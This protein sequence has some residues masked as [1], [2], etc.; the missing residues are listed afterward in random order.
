MIKLQLKSPEESRDLSYGDETITIGR[1]A[2]CTIQLRD[3]KASRE[4]AKIEKVGDEYRLVDLDSNNG[5][6]INSEGVTIRP[7]RKGDRISIG[8]CVITVVDVDT[9]VPAAPEEPA[10]PAPVPYEKKLEVK[11]KIEGVRGGA[12]KSA[13]RTGSDPTRLLLI[14]GGVAAVLVVA[15]VLI[16]VVANQPMQPR[17]DQVNKAK[18]EK[19]QLDRD[20]RLDAEAKLSEAKL[21]AESG[22]VDLVELRRHAQKYDGLL[23]KKDNFSTLVARLEAK[24][25]PRRD[26]ASF[27]SEFASV[28]ARVESA[29]RQRQYGEALR[30]IAGVAAGA[31]ESQ[32]SQV[33]E[34]LW[35]AKKAVYADFQHVIMEGYALENRDEYAKAKEVYS[36]AAP[37]FRDTEYHALL[38]GRPDDIDLIVR[39]K[40]AERK[41]KTEIVRNEPKKDEP[42]KDDPGSKKDEPV[43][44]IDTS[45]LLKKL[46]NAINAGAFKDVKVKLSDLT[47][48]PTSADDSGIKFKEGGEVAWTDIAPK[49]M[50]QLF[51]QLKYE[52]DELLLL[53]EWSHEKGLEAEA[54]K[55]L[56]RYI[57]GKKENKT[58]ADGAIARWRGVPV[59]DGGYTY[60]A[61]TASWEDRG[62]LDNRLAIEDAAKLGRELASLTDIKRVDP[63]VGKLLAHFNNANLKQETRDAVKTAALEALQTYK[64][65]RLESIGQR[66]KSAVGFE[67]LRQLKMELNKRRGEAI[68]VIYDPKIYLPEDHPDWRKGDKANGQTE[69]DRLVEQVRQLWEEGGRFAASLDP[70]IKR[71]IEGVQEINA[72]HLRQFGEEPSEDDLKDFDEIMNNL[73]SR[74]DLKNFALTSK[75]R[76]IWEW[77]R[78]VDRY[79]ETLNDP[80]VGKEEKDHFK[81]VNDYREMMGRR[82]LFLDARLCRA[83]KKHSA[84]QDREGRIWHEG[85]DG[86]PQSRAQAE[87]FPAGV[88]ENVAIGYGSPAEVWTR[89]WYRASDHHRNGLSD[90]WNC[91]GYGYVGRVGSQNFSS[92]SPPKGK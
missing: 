35:Q 8:E 75:E 55:T 3:R 84:A 27:D 12:G 78:W 5:T 47:G 48:E 63:I 60:N 29:L 31:E 50:F 41:P 19:E 59:P 49:S 2:E 62:E 22:E 25:P 83:T 54:N 16:V 36:G 4:H 74:I 11:K 68:K 56:S 72:K 67:K 28:R 46:L 87:G 24:L 64:K 92:I 52:G 57:A 85:P 81:V 21:A 33:N 70:Q 53:A 40:Q 80:S 89:G 71:D 32:Q 1:K 15:V 69:V 77:N 88:G 13:L 17:P 65:K 18:L 86:S 43:A 66:A 38:A 79:N 34:L 73:N 6:R 39:A 37:R 51:G 9:P 42:K 14:L 45:S 91:G 7:L 82:R 30:L 61:R 76:Q 20:N 58:K 44:K 23:P 26:P 10:A 90:A